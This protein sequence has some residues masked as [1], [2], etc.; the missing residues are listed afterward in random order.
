M[1]RCVAAA[2]TA[3]ADPAAAHATAV[4]TTVTT[5]LA[6][7]FS[8]AAVAAAAAAALAPALAPASIAPSAVAAEF[9]VHRALL[10]RKSHLRAER[11]L[12]MPRGLQCQRYARPSRPK[13]LR[14]AW[15]RFRHLHL[16]R[17]LLAWAG[18][19]DADHL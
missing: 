10:R 6:A 1:R 19:L 9:N 7:S 12:R 3:A 14:R 18:K 15:L 4:T 11:Q 2:L 8:S 5:T 16:H 13:L 17:G